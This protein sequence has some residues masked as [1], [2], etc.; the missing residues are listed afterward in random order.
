M[1]TGV[2]RSGKST[3][4]KAFSEASG[5]PFVQTTAS[6]VFQ[7]MGLD[8][9]VDY[10]MSVRLDIQQRI[11]EA[12]EK[13]CK[14]YTATLFITDRTPV[15]FLA[16]TL[17]DCQR[18]NVPDELHSRIERYMDDCI[19]LTNWLFPV[20]VVVQPGIQIVEEANKAPGNVPYVEH[21]N[22]LII[23]IVTSERIKAE[24]FFIPRK[25]TDLEDRVNCIDFS[26]RKASDRLNAYVKKRADDGDPVVLH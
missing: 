14:P 10:P 15:D 3:L 2:H 25:M 21:I 8:P 1:L 11:L 5:V 13:Q 9:K 24:R 12:F 26:I 20:L 22:N 18:S 6:K 7:D 17:A 4:A 16:Y 19:N 23:G